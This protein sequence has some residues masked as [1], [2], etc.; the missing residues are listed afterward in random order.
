MPNKQ[1][2]ALIDET[3]KAVRFGA[4]SFITFYRCF[5]LHFDWY[6]RHP[7]KEHWNPNDETKIPNL[8]SRTLIVRG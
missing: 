3:G 2:I 7:F 6:Y 4:V 1:T 5:F 8:I